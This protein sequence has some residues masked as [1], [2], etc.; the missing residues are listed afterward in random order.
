MSTFVYAPGIRIYIKTESA[1]TLD[2]SDDLIDYTLQRR[3]DGPSVLNFSIQNVHR[4]YDGLF[5]PNDEVIV[6][7]KRV[8]WVRVFT[9]LLNSVPLLTLWP[10]VVAFSASCSLK[11]LQYWYWD[12]Q[13]ASSWAE[14]TNAMSNG[15]GTA[16]GGITNVILALLRD[17]VG[18]PANKAHIGAIPPNWFKLVIPYAQTLA[19]QLVSADAQVTNFLNQYGTGNVGGT[20]VDGSS[21]N[22]TPTTVQAQGLF[23]NEVGQYNAEQLAN[24]EIIIRVGKRRG[25]ADNYIAGALA[26]AIGESHLSATIPNQQGDGGL[27]LFQQGPGWGSV[28]RRTD[29][30]QT[31]EHFFAAFQSTPVGVYAGKSAV[32][33]ALYVND[34]WSNSSRRLQREPAQLPAHEKYYAYAQR[35]V[36]IYNSATVTGTAGADAVSVAAAKE[37]VAKQKGTGGAIPMAY[38]FVQKA[39]TLT[40]TYPAIPYGDTTLSDIKRNPPRALGCSGFI[41]WVLYQYFGK[42]PSGWSLQWAEDQYKWCVSHGGKELPLSEAAKTQGALLI[43]HPRGNK[44]GHV[45]ISVGDG[46]TSVGATNSSHYA[47]A[48]TI[49]L[50]QFD[51][52]VLMP[53]FD[54]SQ[55]QNGRPP[56]VYGTGATYDSNGNPTGPATEPYSSTA[57]FDPTNPIDRLFGDLIAPGPNPQEAFEQSMALAFAGPRALLNDQPLLPYIKNLVNAS[58]RSFCSA[59]NG[60]FMAWFP[61]YYGLWGTAAIMTI[62]AVELQDFYVEWTDD[63]FVTHQYTTAGTVNYFDGFQ[64][65][66]NPTF[67]PPDSGNATPFNDDRLVTAGIASIDIPAIM[68][69]LFGISLDEAEAEKFRQFIYR[70]FGARPD[71]KEMD[72]MVGK[73]AEIFSAMYYFMRQWT[74]QYNANVPLT[75]MPELWPGMLIQVPEY[76]FQAYVTAV[77]H[78]GQMGEG[79]GHQTMVN[80]AAPARLPD[81]TN[82]HHLI[83]LPIASG[84]LESTGNVVERVPMTAQAQKNAR[85]LD[86]SS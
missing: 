13:L 46:R 68:Y 63:Y 21:V 74:Y 26:V 23:K 34:G 77:T 73:V 32:W 38:D 3:S 85:L 58:M 76:N 81:G 28:A 83:G 43:R 20:T 86:G 52:A 65:N 39:I 1:G 10:R 78:S 62:E 49:Y 56:Q 84:V 19:D 55:A 11:R 2:I 67:T 59:P 24:A 64:G 79:G 33:A 5:T 18:W 27:G 35:L 15:H 72:G 4:K 71:F 22:G 53:W 16:D 80:I 45:E 25:I 29:P 82:S 17:V 75:F 54:Y 9:G 36:T 44:V 8:R 41:S 42:L 66:M 14:A 31:S 37:A 69:A 6:E 57:G 47:S 30:V 70:K 60:D 61:D 7:M 12:P 48:H 40:S 51:T 50:D